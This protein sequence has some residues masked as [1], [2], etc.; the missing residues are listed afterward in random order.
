MK[1]MTEQEIIRIREASDK[2]DSNGK[3]VQFLYLLMRDH[4]PTGIVEEITSKCVQDDRLCEF[5]NGWL[6]EYALDVAARLK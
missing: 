5:C 2:F 1:T 4:I 3:L 6:G